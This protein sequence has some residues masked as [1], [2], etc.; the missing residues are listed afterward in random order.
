MKIY[1]Y[2]FLKNYPGA[3][4]PDLWFP[5][6]D[7]YANGYL[8][9]NLPRH[10]EKYR[11]IELVEKKRRCDYPPSGWIYHV[12]Y[13]M[14]LNCMCVEIAPEA[15]EAFIQENVDEGAGLFYHDE[16]VWLE[17]RE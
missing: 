1:S 10:P 12:R 5:V 3:E 17:E 2:T 14:K 4:Q 11:N 6:N 8:Y 13:E 15:I 9:N 7:R 16:Q